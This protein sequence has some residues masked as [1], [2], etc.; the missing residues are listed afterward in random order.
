MAVR[1]ALIKK[2]AQARHDLDTLNH[3][4]CLTRAKVEKYEKE[5]E[6][7]EEKVI[8]EIMV[9]AK[10]KLVGQKVRIKDKTFSGTVIVTGVKPRQKNDCLFLLTYRWPRQKEELILLPFGWDTQWKIISR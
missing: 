4:I 7:M 5:K 8:K 6:E 3:L 1:D 10:S 2:I 9:L